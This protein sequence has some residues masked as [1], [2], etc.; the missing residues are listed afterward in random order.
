MLMI[1]FLTSLKTL[2][3][4][5]LSTLFLLK[6]LKTSLKELMKKINFSSRL[7]KRL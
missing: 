1:M 5:L 2:L 4:M 3:T 7:T 6:A